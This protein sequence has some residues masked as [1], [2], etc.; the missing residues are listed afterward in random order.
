MGGTDRE[1]V[2]PEEIME[3]CYIFGEGETKAPH[4]IPDGIRQLWDRLSETERLIAYAT[5]EYAKES[6]S[7]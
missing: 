3:R 2:T 6:M 7:W 1:P 4:G 5:A